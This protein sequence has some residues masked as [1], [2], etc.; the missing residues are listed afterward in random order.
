MDV[1]RRRRRVFAALAIFLVALLVRATYWSEI[2]GGALDEWQRFDQ[3]D[4]ATY[5]A[6]AK[7]FVALGWLAPDPVH[8][9][10]AWQSIAPPEKWLAWYGPHNFHQAPGYSFVLAHWT[11]ANVDEL[12]GIK[13]VQLALGAFSAVLVFLLAESLA[14]FASAIVAGLLI[15]IYGP[16]Y[17]LELQ[18]LRDGPMLCAMLAILALLVHELRH[19]VGREPS[20]PRWILCALLGSSVGVFHMF[21]EMGTVLFVVVALSLAIQRWKSGPKL[22]LAAVGL[23]A[24]GYLVGFAPLLVRNL[25]VGA[26]PFA[27]SCRTLINFAEAN[28][29]DAAEGGATF[30]APNESFVKI[31]DA[32]DGSF[33]KMLGGVWESYHGDVGLLLHNWGLRFAAIWKWSEEAD[34]TSYYFYRLYTPS[35]GFSPTFAWLFPLGFAGA[36][37]LAV[38]AWR[39]RRAASDGLAQLWNRAPHGHVAMILAL[40]LVAGSLSFVHTVA[41][42]RLYVTPFF[43]V[44]GAAAL[45]QLFASLRASRIGASASVVGAIFVGA[46]LQ[47]SITFDQEA[48]LLRP[49]DFFVAAKISV[50]QGRYDVARAFTDDGA[51]RYTG[52]FNLYNALGAN[53]ESRGEW[54]RAAD[55]YSQVPPTDPNAPT[56]RQGLDRC[57]NALR[58]KS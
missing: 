56:A 19:D 27:V 44:Y 11:G 49:A 2:R 29:A 48:E 36:A 7:Q 4:M 30:I 15:A 12:T 13:S 1:L 17:S 21:H 42:F 16:L 3:T 6:Q 40:A 52:D 39:A 22:A 53:L 26:K 58:R 23:C 51:R 20:A 57:A 54:R 31:I 9:Y 43:F 50:E 14:G 35:L 8:P 41:R 28:Q 38:G 45:V 55:A 32:A 25:E 18:I 34:N 24:V 5:L 10:H 46:I 47:R 33:L 37:M